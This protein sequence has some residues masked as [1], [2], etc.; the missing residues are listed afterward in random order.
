MQVARARNFRGDWHIELDNEFIRLRTPDDDEVVP[1]EYE[2][3]KIKKLS[4]EAYCDDGIWYKWFIYIENADSDL[5]I[6]F[7]LGPFLKE[8]IVD[9]MKVLYGI[10]VVE[11]GI[12]GVSHKWNYSLGFKIKALLKSIFGALVFFSFIIGA[13]FYLVK[14]LDSSLLTRW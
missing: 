2:R 4:R 8:K 3:K 11:V 7:D 5:K 6:Q 10:E 14:I 1:F 9:K 13:F 12:D